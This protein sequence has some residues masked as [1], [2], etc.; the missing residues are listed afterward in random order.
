MKKRI[1]LRLIVLLVMILSLLNSA[2]AQEDAP[3]EIP[4]LDMLSLVP[5][6]LQSRVSEMY[7]NDRVAIV[8]AYEGALMPEDWA[9]FEGLNPDNEDPNDPRFGEVVWWRIYLNNSSSQLGRNITAGDEMEQVTGFDFFEVERELFYGTPPSTGVI[10][11]GGF[12]LESVR[13]AYSALGLV[14]WSTEG[15]ELWCPEAGC[16]TGLETNFDNLNRA[17]PFGGDLGRRQPM[18]LGDG[19]LMS[20]ADNT[21]VDAHIQT[22][23]GS[24]PSLADVPEYA[25][26]VEAMSSIGT[27]IQAM[28][29]DGEILLSV[30]QDSSLV[31]NVVAGVP[32]EQI[33]AL[34]REQLEDFQELPVYSLM[35]LGDTATEDQHIGMVALVY[36]DAETAE[37]A[38]DVIQ[39]RLTNYESLRYARAM[40]DILAERYL[41]VET[42]VV[43]SGDLAV[44]LVQ[45]VTP[46][47]TPEEII[48][49]TDVSRDHGDLERTFPGAAY[50]L[51]VDAVI[52]RDMGWLSTVTR[53]ELEGLLDE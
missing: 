50:R 45:L 39:N 23:N 9:E 2:A 42:S 22:V 13:E 26:G 49:I 40:A 44:L 37:L 24:T 5:N 12:D 47:A 30:Q 15:A 3:A 53:A 4:L 27:L 48:A 21:V 20:S 25:A 18:V 33:R 35:M 51:L 16:D 29:L 11:E 32:I 10:L 52:S 43:E 17:N 6:T 7:F 34:I 28:I 19:Y 31:S 8:N 46:K 14:E 38:G 36:G 41:T 1:M